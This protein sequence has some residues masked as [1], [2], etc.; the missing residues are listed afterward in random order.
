MLSTKLVA[1]LLSLDKE[2]LACQLINSS[3][4]IYKQAAHTL[5]RK[6]REDNYV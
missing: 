2:H 4:D 6:E 5:S 1:V 3:Q